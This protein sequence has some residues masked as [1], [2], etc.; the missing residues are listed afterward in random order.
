MLLQML[1]D[2]GETRAKD[3]V[4]AEL[5][6]WRHE[7]KLRGFA[8]DLAQRREGETLNVRL[9]DVDRM[10]PF[11][12][13]LLVGMIYQTLGYAITE[14][15]KTGDQGA[16]VFLEKAGEKTVVQTKLY[17]APVGNHAVQEVIAARSHYRCQHAIVLTNNSF[18]R[19]A[20]E[21]AASTKV[22]LVDRQQLNAMLQ[23]FNRSP[24]NYSRLADLLKPAHTVVGE[25][26][27]IP[28]VLPADE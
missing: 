15:R 13:E 16:D 8:L 6:T 12:F 19:S 7:H 11:K 10:D 24:K 20:I 18:T 1:S 26:A 27:S 21:L 22:H 5:S 2:K 23:T 14:T 25:S 28:C 4:M 9:E 17:T 3:V